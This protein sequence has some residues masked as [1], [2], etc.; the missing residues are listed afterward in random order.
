MEDPGTGITAMW[1][2]HSMP[3]I[4]P[5]ICQVSQHRKPSVNQE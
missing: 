2:L 5:V 4:F 3:S 1:P